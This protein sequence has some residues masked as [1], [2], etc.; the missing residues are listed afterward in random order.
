MY[1]KHCGKSIDDNSVFCTYCGKPV[2]TL[3]HTFTVNQSLDDNNIN[4]DIVQKPVHAIEYED[5]FFFKNVPISK[6]IVLAI[7][8]YLLYYYRLCNIC[9]LS[10]RKYRTTYWFN[11][12]LNLY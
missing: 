5:G 12:W 11:H 10:S 7:L 6:K 9:S 2:Q 1:C 3:Q 4:N 8:A